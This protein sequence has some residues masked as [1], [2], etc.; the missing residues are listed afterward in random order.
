VKEREELLLLDEQLRN[1]DRNI[2]QE[3][4][5]FIERGEIVTRNEAGQRAFKADHLE[6]AGHELDFLM[7]FL[8]QPAA[9]LTDEELKSRIEMLKKGDMSAHY[10]ASLLRIY[11]PGV[12][13]DRFADELRL[14][15]VDKWEGSSI[16]K[17]R[18]Q[19]QI[20]TLSQVPR[21]VTGES[22]KD[23]AKEK[24]ERFCEVLSQPNGFVSEDQRA[25]LLTELQKLKHSGKT[26]KSFCDRLAQLFAPW[27]KLEKSQG[28]SVRSR[29]R[30]NWS[31]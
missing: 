27:W 25:G 8:L 21:R 19:K 29:K 22:R 30:E 28:Q 1:A 18:E 10:L 17:S 12:L 15:A 14:R 11:T 24:F 6:R 20:I 23:R 4:R 9:E 3:Y 7:E 16:K 2:D 5:K 13:Y 26:T 31:W